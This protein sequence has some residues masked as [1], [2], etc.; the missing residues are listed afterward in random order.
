M[1]SDDQERSRQYITALRGRWQRVGELAEDVGRSPST[2]N[3]ARRSMAALIPGIIRERSAPARSGVT[4]VPAG[5]GSYEQLLRRKKNMAI[6][7]AAAAMPTDAADLRP[8]SASV[9]LS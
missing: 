2:A 4:W 7:T 1:C 9:G 6:D 3:A 5:G 8:P